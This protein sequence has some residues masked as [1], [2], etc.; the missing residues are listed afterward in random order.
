MSEAADSRAPMLPPHRGEFRVL[1][2]I[3]PAGRGA[4]V[5]EALRGE[6][7]VISACAH[8]ARGI[9]THDP[10]HRAYSDEKQV[11]TALVDAGCAD[12]VFNFLY[13]AAGL[14]LPHA[15]MIMMARAFRGSGVAPLPQPS[16]PGRDSPM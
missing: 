4:Q 8:H 5:L 14:D 1:T 7:G 13:H 10:R 15:G 12:E 6:A 11:I 16:L 2:C 3:M 9:G